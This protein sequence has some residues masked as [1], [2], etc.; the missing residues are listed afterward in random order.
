[1]AFD[2]VSIEV[3]SNQSLF[4][5]HWPICAM[6]F[7]AEFCIRIP[8]LAKAST[9]VPEMWLS[10]EDIVLEADRPRKFVFTAHGTQ[11][12]EFEVA[13]NA[14]PTVDEYTVLTKWADTAYYIVTYGTDTATRGTYHVAVE[15]GIA[16]ITIEL[17][18]GEY[19]VQARVPDRDALA[20]LHE[21]CCENDIPYRLERIYQEELPTGDAYGLTDPQR[22]A[23]QQAYDRGYFDSPREAT[24][25]AI[26]DDLGIS[27]QAVADRL[28]RGHK[29]LIE[30]TIT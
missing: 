18:D 2:Y 14:D 23:L 19:T 21:Y 8:P 30:A 7:I 4:L 22:T 13:L 10:G 3:Q 9:A 28:R 17:Q 12:D 11:F 29:R 15:E 24:L 20:T 6:S 16:Y 27:R 5:V 26:G 25:D 1:M